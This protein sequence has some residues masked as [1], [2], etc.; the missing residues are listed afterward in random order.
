[1]AKNFILMMT[2]FFFF[3]NDFDKKFFDGNKK[4]SLDNDKKFFFDYAK[5]CLLDSNKKFSSDDDKKFFFRR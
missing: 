2:K 1:M 5:K 3:D 4:M